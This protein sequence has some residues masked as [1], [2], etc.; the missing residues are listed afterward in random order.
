MP[1]MPQSARDIA[2]A[3]YLTTA[4]ALPA[5]LVELVSRSVES[6]EGEAMTD[7][8]D[9]LPGRM[10]ADF[11]AQVRGDNRGNGTVFSCP[12]CGGHLWQVDEKELVRFQ[13]HVGHGYY[14][15]ALLDEQTETLEAALWTA[16]RTFREQVVLAR[17]LAALERHRG[18]QAAAAQFEEKA[19]LAE[20]YSELIKTH[21]LHVPGS[22]AVADPATGAEPTLP[23]RGAG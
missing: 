10:S 7:P 3:D 8:L 18:N 6:D 2:G 9:K 13:C 4:A 15:P 19:V 11:S 16:V 17:Q 21:V 5:L 20:R 23:P 12:E 22:A 14:G 1:A